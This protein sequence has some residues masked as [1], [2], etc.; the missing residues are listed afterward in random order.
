MTFISVITG[1]LVNS[2]GVSDPAG[3]RQRLV[4]T[5]QVMEKKYRAVTSIYRGDGFQLAL[6][7]ASDAYE[8]ALL[9]RAGLIAGTRAAPERWDARM[10]VAL[11]STDLPVHEANSEVHVASGRMLDTMDKDRMAI[12]VDRPGAALQAMAS[13]AMLFMDDIAIGWT[14][15][16]AEVL[17]DYLLHK[18]AHQKIANR[19][20]VSR[21]TVTLALKRAKSRLVDAYITEMKAMTEKVYGDQ[22]G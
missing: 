10:A 22:L 2:T 1:D 21:P 16:E 4:K 8:A 9:I 7:E 5:L 3:F 12:V 18:D 13:L 19:M 17:Q 6:P 14:A 11:G 20:G 15:R